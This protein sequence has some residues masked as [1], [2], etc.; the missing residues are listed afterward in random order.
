MRD[1][2]VTEFITLDGVIQAPKEWTGP[3]FSDEVVAYKAEE[4]KASDGILLGRVTYELYAAEWPHHAGNPFFFEKM[5]GLPKYVAS[6]TLTNPAWNNSTVL[7]NDLAAE[8][9]RL[10]QQPGT[11][12]IVFGSADLVRWLLRNDLVDRYQLQL[13]PLV[14]GSGK[15]L[16]GTESGTAHLKLTETRSLD[17]GVMV[18]RYERDPVALADASSSRSR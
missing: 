18:L 2:V 16:F 17:T 11:D 4:L 15:R 5:N 13:F 12:I 7:G 3:Y 9:L 6:T 14:L 10:K 8:L 1:I